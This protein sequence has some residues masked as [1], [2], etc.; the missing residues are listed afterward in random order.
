[1]S[2]K[3]DLHI[4]TSNSDG[5]YS[6][7]E[8]VDKAKLLNLDI[9]SITDHDS[10]AAF[11]EVSVYAS[12]LGIEVIPGVELSSDIAGKEVHILGYMFDVANK[13]LNCYLS[14]FQE[15]RHR[16]AEKIVKKLNLLGSDITIYDVLE[17]A[18]SSVI[19]RPHIA[20]ALV[21]KGFV[22]NYYEAFNKY[23]G[24][25]LPAWEKKVHISPASAFKIINDAGGLSFIAHPDNFPSQIIKDLIDA[26]VDGIEAVH[27]SHNVLQQKY[28]KEIA[29][30][31]FLL[32]SGGSDF[33][34]GTRNDDCNFGKYYINSLNLENMR[35]QLIGK[36][37]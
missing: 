27:P 23:L 35:K 14:F 21:K 10:I 2:G 25:D 12:N 16:R 33:H 17:C 19:S 18:G 5:F 1:M 37:A 28:Y 29:N 22:N 15:E 9:I 36:T 8:I 34:G 11:N 24:N 30:S 6:S 20:Q 31:Y 13:E 4:H 7:K 26:G 3:A 32:N